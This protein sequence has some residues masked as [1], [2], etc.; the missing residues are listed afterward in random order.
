MRRISAFV[1][2]LLLLL[3]AVAIAEASLAGLL[4]LFSVVLKLRTGIELGA[5]SVLF[6]GPVSYYQSNVALFSPATVA[7]FIF[8]AASGLAAA[9]W[10]FQ[11]W[12][13]AR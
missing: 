13:P 2:A 1:S 9:A 12:K 5:A 4:F 7:S 8:T 11:R 6:A 3:L 10:R